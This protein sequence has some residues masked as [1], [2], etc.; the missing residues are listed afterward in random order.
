MMTMKWILGFSILCVW[1]TGCGTSTPYFLVES[2]LVESARQN[3]KPDITETPTFR[4]VNGKVQIVGLR[5]PDVCADQG[6]S[7][8]GGQAQLQL[9]VL[10]TRC[11][12][13][14]A[15]L[16]RALARAGYQVVSWSAIQQMATRQEKPLLEA[17]AE[18]EIDVL[19]QVNALERIDIQPARD[20]RWERSFYKAT[21]GGEQRSSAVVEQDRARSF[22]RLIGGKEASFGSGLRV[23]AMINVSAVWVESGST[24]W[25]YEWTVI[26]EVAVDPTV[27]VLV[28]C[29][30]SN[31][32]EV[33]RKRPTG[34]GGPVAGSISGISSAGDPVDRTQ[35]IFSELVRDLV[36]DLAERFAGRR[37]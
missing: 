33:E 20:A 32:F 13:E 8:S 18:L 37:S 22:D 26:D 21:V 27:Q 3:A 9:G 30:D 1:M 2:H 19:L 15:E 36:T 28:D 23:G 12:V 25:F 6:L 35:A 11:G 7:G 24:I 17:A 5:P 34:D 4:A 29:E 10:R 31:C 16:E 14:M